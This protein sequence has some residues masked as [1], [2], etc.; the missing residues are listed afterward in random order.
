MEEVEAGS[1]GKDVVPTVEQSHR[2]TILGLTLGHRLNMGPERE[3]A[4]L[5]ANRDTNRLKAARDTQSGQKMGAGGAQ[6]ETSSHGN[7]K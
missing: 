3:I 6:L 4:T 5:V 7:G 1:R 2:E